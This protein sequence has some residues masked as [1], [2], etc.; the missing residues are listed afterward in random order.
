M[1]TAADVRQV[2]D[3]HFSQNRRLWDTCASLPETLYRQPLSYSVGSIHNQMVHL[4]DIDRLWFRDLRGEPESA[5]DDP[6]NYPDRQILR[7]AWD[8][9][10]ASMRTY[11]TAMQEDDLQ[12]VVQI[13]PRP[14]EIL[15]FKVWQGLLHIVNHGTDHRAQTLAMLHT[16]G[17]ATFAQD[18]A[19]SFMKA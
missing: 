17:A 2:F 14:G 15:R 6:A 1:I 5:F 8:E 12:R 10:E 3:Y 9:V 11:L 4:M 18:F 7:T 19:N 16:L 13:E